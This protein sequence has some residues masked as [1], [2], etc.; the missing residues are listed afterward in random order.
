MGGTSGI[1]LTLCEAFTRH[2]RRTLLVMAAGTGKTRTTV[3]LIDLV[4]RANQVRRI[5]YLADR[6]TLLDQALADGF[7]AHLPNEPRDRIYTHHVDQT[8]RLFFTTAQTLSLCF[9]QFSPGFFDLIVFDEAHRS[10][11]RRCT[12]IVEY[13]DAQIVALTATPARLID[14]DT[15]RLFSGATGAPTFLYDHPEAV[16]EKS[17]V[18]FSLTQAHTGFPRAGVAGVDLTEED[19]NALL[20]Q[21]LDP[22]LIDHSGTEL[23][24]NITNRDILL[25]QWEEIMTACLKD[26]SGRLPGKTIVFAM[27]KKHAQGLRLVYEEM[28]PQDVDLAQVIDS[29]VERVR[30]GSYGDGLLTKFKKNDLP[31]IAITVDLLETGVDFPEVVNLVFLKPVQSRIKLWQMIGRG[32]RNHEACSHPDRLPAAKKTRFKIIDFWQNDFRLPSYEPAAA[33]GPVLVNLF[34]TRLTLLESQLPDL[35]TAVAVQAVADLRAMLDR[36]P[37]DAFPV[38]KVWTEIEAAWEPAFWQSIPPA[39]IK[40]LGRCV[41]PLLRFVAGVDVSAETFFDQ[42]ERLKFQLL[43]N[44]PAPALLQ[45]IAEDVRLL[46]APTVA[47][48]LATATAVQLTQ[49]A[50]ELAPKMHDR[51][52]RISAFPSLDLPD[53]I[54]TG[55]LIFLRDGHRVAVEEYRKQVEA[56]VLALVDKNPAIEAIRQGRD[57]PEGRLVELERVLSRELGHGALE[58]TSGNLRQAYGLKLDNFLAFLRH[59]LALDAIPDYGQIVRH[60]FEKHV[61][62]HA[63]QP[64]QIRLLHTVQEIFLRKKTF[65]ETDLHEPPFSIFGENSVDRLFTPEEIGE[66]LQLIEFLAA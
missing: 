17:L 46:S 55:G 35:T 24:A 9:Q 57:V 40:F 16:R 14:R 34:N 19:R 38:R 6:D 43:R 15:I 36:I 51:P 21:G 13:F 5:L 26:Q 7:T 49:L 31:R 42:I 11:F 39:K 3:A 22:D 27:T 33:E 20:E 41:G 28:F 62:A 12:E 60:S 59:L 30:N 18:D 66:L 44:A 29:G 53:L 58:L 63:Y 64:E 65:V 25:G 10:N 47:R 2:E 52:N 1:T 37:R 56:R 48:N 54:A 50:R 4:L 8:K 61:A 23:E 32:T 45:S